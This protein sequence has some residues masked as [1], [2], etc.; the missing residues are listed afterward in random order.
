MFSTLLFAYV[1]KS[2]KRNKMLNK[3]VF[4]SELSKSG[5][6]GSIMEHKPT[7]SPS[8]LLTDW[9]LIGFVVLSGSN[10]VFC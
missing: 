7:L 5:I 4:V 10:E 2:A 8:L 9:I 3:R 1:K 6:F